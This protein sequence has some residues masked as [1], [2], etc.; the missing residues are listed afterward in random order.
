MEPHELHAYGIIAMVL[1]SKSN[2]VFPLG[3]TTAY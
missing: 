3:L 2:A 1:A